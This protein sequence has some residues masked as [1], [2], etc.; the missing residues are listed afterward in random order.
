MSVLRTLHQTLCCPDD[1]GALRL[2]PDRMVCGACGREF[3]VD[4]DLVSLVA[5]AASPVGG[6][7][8]YRR[9][10]LA[11]RQESEEAPAPV[12]GWRIPPMGPAYL[13]ERKRRQVE[14]ARRLL[15]EGCDTRDL[16]CDFSAGPGYYT[17]AYAR[18]WRRV[19]HCDLCVNSIHAARA[20]ARRQGLDNILF[21]RMDY[22][23]PPFRGSL[24]RIL[25]LDTLARGQEH[26][27][28]LLRSIAA[29]LDTDGVAVIDFH[30]WWHNPLRRLGLLPNNFGKN[31]SYRRRELA[32]VLSDAD[33]PRYECFP[34]HQEVDP[35]SR[36]A[37][38]LTHVLPPT[39]WM[40]RFHHAAASH[41]RPA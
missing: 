35:G 6:A 30:N 37:G 9:F 3:V 40:F 4:G 31:R 38:L 15:E 28:A 41:S 14:S 36:F 17:L 32:G 8:P 22:L 27:R 11:A 25:C 12:T 5:S 20:A 10:Y 13:F 2:Y 1:G 29:A 18:S 16:V 19:I 26:E 21:V 34:F 24:P 33:I 23:R 7:G 39:R